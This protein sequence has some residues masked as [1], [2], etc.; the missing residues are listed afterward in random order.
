MAASY[1]PFSSYLFK[2]TGVISCLFWFFVHVRILK[3][4]K[5]GVV[6]E[7]LVVY[8]NLPCVPAT[9]G[10]N[11]AVLRNTEVSGW[12]KAQHWLLDLDYSEPWDNIQLRNQLGYRYRPDTG[13]YRPAAVPHTGDTVWI[14]TFR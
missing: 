8:K 10:S 6:C 3:L 4:L 12:A 14:C 2:L 13:G 1:P 7:C 11:L 5:L 9:D